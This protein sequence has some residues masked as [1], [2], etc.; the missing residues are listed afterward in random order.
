MSSQFRIPNSTINDRNRVTDQLVGKLRELRF[1]EVCTQDYSIPIILEHQFPIKLSAVV[2]NDKRLFEQTTYFMKL[3]IVYMNTNDCDEFIAVIATILANHLSTFTIHTSLAP[4]QLPYVNR[5][6]SEVLMICESH[7]DILSIWL[8]GAPTQETHPVNVLSLQ[9]IIENFA[10]NELDTFKTTNWEN[11][12]KLSQDSSEL[13]AHLCSQEVG[14]FDSMIELYFFPPEEYGLLHVSVL[15]PVLSAVI[16]V[17][18]YA[19][20]ELGLKYFGKF[21]NTLKR[22]LNMSVNCDNSILFILQQSLNLNAATTLGRL[23]DEF[24]FQLYLNDKLQESRVVERFLYVLA[25]VSL[26]QDQCFL[27]L[28]STK[29]SDQQ[30]LTFNLAFLDQIRVKTMKIHSGDAQPVSSRFTTLL[31][32]YSASIENYILDAQ[33][34][35]ISQVFPLLL[36]YFQNKTSL[37]ASL[38]RFFLILFLKYNMFNCATFVEIINYL[39]ESYEIYHSHLKLYELYQYDSVELSKIVG[40]N[41]TPPSCEIL[42]HYGI[43][44]QA[45]CINYVTLPKQLELCRQL[46][47]DF[48]ICCKVKNNTCDPRNHNRENA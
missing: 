48:Y 23:F 3:L 5:L 29:E 32:Q 16:K 4:Y 43:E 15:E 40:Q 36:Q 20:Y 6:V 25:D 18:E 22:H 8:I 11:F 42:A 12:I 30:F 9:Q 45:Q 13:N 19:S 1:S 24:S 35:L 44:H 38:N 47:T 17:M 7:T 10:M 2:C 34:A 26:K 39:V 21:I 41:V 46:I 28:V 33:C 37:N 31:T 14:V 27:K